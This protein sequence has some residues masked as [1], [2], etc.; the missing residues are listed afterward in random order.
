MS[1]KLNHRQIRESKFFFGSNKT[2]LEKKEVEEK[3]EAL[4]KYNNN[5]IRKKKKNQRVKSEKLLKI[6]AP[7]ACVWGHLRYRH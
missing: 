3:E 4:R 6:A 2:K 5:V 1:V 7:A